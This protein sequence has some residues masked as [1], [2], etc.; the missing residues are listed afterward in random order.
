M[1]LLVLA[2]HYLQKVHDS[3]GYD[4]EMDLALVSRYEINS[5]Y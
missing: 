4:D 3:S 2:Y 1:P 5:Q